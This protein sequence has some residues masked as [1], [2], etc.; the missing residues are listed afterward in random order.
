MNVLPPRQTA[1]LEYLVRHQ[2]EH[3][4]APTMSEMSNAL[5]LS[6]INAAYELLNKLEAKGC[7]ER[8]PGASRTIRVLTAPFPR[9]NQLPLIGRIAAGLPITAAENV[10]EYLDVSPDLFRP[11]ADVL[12]R[13]QGH[14][15]INAGI[16]DNDIVG[17]HLQ[18]DAPNGSIVGAVV[19]DPVTEDPLLTLKTYRRNRDTIT[20][21]SENDDQKQYPPMVFNR[22]KDSI[23]V[24]GIHSGLIR[25]GKP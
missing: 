24:F 20:L 6:T 15:M 3:G 19:I 21:L 11:R 17:V 13:V 22:R 16:F 10:V 7:I 9:L 12:F 14:S 18:D 1:L 4:Y 25:T 8:T 5:G 2:A 23:Q